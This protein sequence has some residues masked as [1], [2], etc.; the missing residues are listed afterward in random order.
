MRGLQERGAVAAL[1]RPG[2]LLVTG[3]VAA[4]VVAADQVTKAVAVAHLHRPV[5]VVGPFGLDLGY[6]TG[7][8]FSLFTADAAVLTA[9][10]VLLV[11]VLCW[12]AWRA[13]NAPVAVAVGLVLGGALGNLC[14]RAAR[15]RVV[16]FVTLTH[17]PTFNVADACI[18]VGIVLLVVFYWRAASPARRPS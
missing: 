8:A 11:A 9:V 16:D 13:P 12:L 1:S 18:T 6:N 4:A 3:A 2:R 17:W 5:H 10:A 15:G 7:S 14:D